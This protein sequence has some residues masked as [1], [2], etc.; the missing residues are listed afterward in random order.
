[1]SMIFSK[2]GSFGVLFNKTEQVAERRLCS[3]GQHTLLPLETSKTL[4]E[5]HLL[6]CGVM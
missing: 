2:S 4:E 3:L 1:M 6:G 5:C